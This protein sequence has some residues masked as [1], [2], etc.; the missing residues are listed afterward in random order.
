MPSSS[1]RTLPLAA[2]VLLASTGGSA[3]AQAFDAVRLFGGMSDQDSGSIGLVALNGREYAG[4]ADRVYRVVPRIDYQWRSGWFAG[5]SNGIG[6]DF[7]KRPDLSYGLRVTADLGRDE[8]R[9]SALSGMGD[10]GARPE[11]GAFLN[12]SPL[13]PLTLTSSLRY[14][15]GR[16]RKGLVADLGAVYS[17]ALGPSWR[18][19]AG[20]AATYVN[21]DYMQDFFGVTP[22]QATTSA[23]REFRPEAGVRDVRTTLSLT[24]LAT[25]RVAVTAALSGSRLQGDA[26]DSVLTQ[27]AGTV[28]GLI[29]VGYSF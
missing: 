4:S 7:A 19:S 1:L 18:V 6:Y 27:K 24:Y 3:F 28:N 16:D 12:Y 14:G 22:E 25:P 15:S 13:R 21:R 11:F 8:E 5:T 23:Y 2:G 10:I 17:F 20:A 29:T 9:S 26:Q